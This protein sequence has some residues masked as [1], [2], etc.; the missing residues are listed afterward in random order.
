M[1]ALVVN[2]LAREGDSVQEIIER[3]FLGAEF[4]ILDSDPD[5]TSN[6]RDEPD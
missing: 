3:C 4:A 1:C 6:L 5:E 2:G